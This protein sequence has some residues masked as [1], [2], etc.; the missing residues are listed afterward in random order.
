MAGFSKFTASFNAS[1]VAA[2]EYLGPQH[3]A[4]I[5]AMAA[6]FHV[7]AYWGWT[8]MPHLRIIDIPVHAMNIR[9]GD[10]DVQQAQDD[11]ESAPQPLVDNTAQMESVVTKLIRK[12]VSK[13]ARK[14][15]AAKP[16]KLTADRAPQQ[17]APAAVSERSDSPRQFV[18]FNQAE[19]PAE[20][21]GTAIG[22]STDSDA[23]VKASY[24]QMISLW[25]QKF[26]LYP[27]S[28]REQGM[29]GSTV[30][31]IRIDRRGNI[32][33]SELEGNTGYPELDRAA[34]DMVRRANP[35]PAVPDEYPAGEMFEFLIPVNYTL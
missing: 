35:V 21:E 10:S 9:L 29:Q 27:E 25:I 32:R 34:L 7:L 11:D 24:E 26:K 15:P 17:Q 13:T 6:I 30:V 14:S 33:W 22:N 31:R 28:A 4:M 18:R 1:R 2:M 3:F 8:M 23:D 20:N 5:F 19:R 16:E 12:P